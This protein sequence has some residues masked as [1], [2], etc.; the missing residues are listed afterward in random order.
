[1]MTS[2]GA[3]VPARTVRRRL[4]PAGLAVLCLVIA[5]VPAA[6]RVS[7]ETAAGLSVTIHEPDDIAAGMLVTAGGT[8]WLRHPTAGEV[9]LE[10]ES[11]PWQTLVPADP[12]VVA[13]AL[14]SVTG[15]QTDLAV[16]VFLLPGLP[17][18]VLGSFARRDAIFLAPGLGP[19]AAETVAWLVTHELGHVLCW[20]AVD[21]RPERWAAY[22]ELRG[23]DP[24]AVDA[25]LPHAE[26]HREIIAEDFR[27]LF[28]GPLAT[29]AGTI[30]NPDL[31]R[32]DAVAGLRELL[33]GYVA[34][35]PRAA[36]PTPVIVASRAYPNP[37]RGLTTVELMVGDAT[38]AAAA[39]PVLEIYDV[40]G[41]LVQRRLDGRL[42]SGRL[43]VTWDGT[44][45][46]GRRVPDGIYLYRIVGGEGVG[47]GRI[48]MV[49]R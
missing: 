11:H 42:A 30:E 32:P 44:D 35:P 29:R 43:Q 33:A 2:H 4:V 38:K 18:G 10:T 7:L 17:A 25:E 3:A 28:G 34:D 27:A 26:R 37:S 21:G 13:A 40:R 45:Q 8:T 47:Q 22:R 48:L 16:D 36:P 14:S 5:S 15:L 6:A 46:S 49:R 20:A 9:A 41:R 39:A 1:M 23:L 31:P 24:A 12:A 19:Q